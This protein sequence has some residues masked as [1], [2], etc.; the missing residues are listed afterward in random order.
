ME[1][2]RG[3]ASTDQQQG[4]RKNMIVVQANVVPYFN[5]ND[6]ERLRPACEEI[7]TQVIKGDLCWPDPDGLQY[8][9]MTVAGLQTH[10]IIDVCVYNYR[11]KHS[12]IKDAAM[13]IK[14]ALNIAFPGYTFA[15]STN[16]ANGGW[17]SDNNTGAI[18][19][20]TSVWSTL[21]RFFKH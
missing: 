12:K 3:I 14:A 11:G 19:A 16:I 2:K 1:M 10:S 13:K 6:L 21:K 5:T 18:V 7:I 20:K 15:V 4:T 17:V 8:M 9:Q